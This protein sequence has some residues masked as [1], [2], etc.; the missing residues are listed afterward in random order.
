[1]WENHRKTH[2]KDPID[3]LKVGHHGSINATPPPVEHRPASKQPVADGVYS[4]LDTILPVPKSGA[5]TTAQALV[6]TER[7][8]Y[9][10]IPDCKVLVN[11][12]GRVSNTRKYGQILKEAG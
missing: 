4:I 10:P 11:L 1:M 5:T 12:A 9:D 6:S 7:E 2:L 8:F 3:F